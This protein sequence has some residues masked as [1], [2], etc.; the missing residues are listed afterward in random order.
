MTETR[1]PRFATWGNGLRALLIGDLVRDHPNA[2][3]WS[4]VTCGSSHHSSLPSQPAPHAANGFRG[5]IRKCTYRA[6]ID[7]STM[8]R[9]E[10]RV[11]SPPSGSKL[12]SRGQLDWLEC[13]L[14]EDPRPPRFPP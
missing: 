7:T 1:C 3:R 8:A 4:L 2:E 13:G 14:F 9:V 6:S 10:W 5:A 11:K 12:E